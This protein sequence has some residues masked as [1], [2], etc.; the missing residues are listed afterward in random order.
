MATIKLD[1]VSKIYNNDGASAVGIQ[2][3]SLELNLGEF[4]AITGESGSGKSTF[5]NVVS[6]MDTYEEGELFIND[7]S[8][9]EFTKA[10]FANYR[11]NYVSFIFQ[12]YNL[13][14]S[15]TVLDNVMLPLISRG[16]K[17]QEAKKIAKDAI[18][19]VG[20]DK[21]IR[22]KATHLSG[23][24][25]Q[26][27]VIARALVS[28]TPIIACDEPTGNLDSE[29]AKSII[30]LLA[31][32]APNKLILF[33]THDYQ[34]ISHVATRHIIL[35]DSHLESDTMIQKPEKIELPQEEK[36]NH[37]SI[38]QSILLGLK[39]VVST[40]KK[41]TLSF[42]ISLLIS[43]S[44]IA[45]L[46]GAFAL[47]EPASEQ[48][49]TVNSTYAEKNHSKNRAAAFG[50]GRNGAELKDFTVDSDVFVDVGNIVSSQYSTVIRT[51]MNFDASEINIPHKGDEMIKIREDNHE[52]TAVNEC[53]L[54]VSKKVFNSF[55]S[56]AY[57][58]DYFYKHFL[59]KAGFASNVT[60]T[61]NGITGTNFS[62]KP[63]AV[64]LID[65]DNEFDYSLI[66][67]LKAIKALHN[68]LYDIYKNSSD[69]INPSAKDD[70][71]GEATYSV[72]DSNIVYNSAYDTFI[73][74]IDFTK[75]YLPSS[76]KGFDLEIS[77]RNSTVTVPTEDIVYNDSLP[78]VVLY[79]SSFLRYFADEYQMASYYTND[80]SKTDNIVSSLQSNEFI[81]YK[82]SVPQSREVKISDHGYESLLMMVGYAVVFTAAA[83][84]IAFLGS[85]ILGV[86]YNSQK[87]DYAIFSSLSFSRKEIRVINFVEISSFFIVTSVFSYLLMFFTSGALGNYF[88]DLAI[89]GGLDNALAATMEGLAT[90]LQS[91]Y[92]YVTTPIFIVAFF[93]FNLIF[94]F[95]VSTWI[96]NKF[97][98]KTLANN[99]RK[100]GELL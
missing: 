43:L 5:L 51:D 24:E 16:Y 49:T 78:G 39:D 10:D 59:T 21:V 53:A 70:Y 11:S 72:A 37:A 15:F 79:K 73:E 89:F 87:K 23:G 40:P 81:A 12:E 57:A 18:S 86:I 41:S 17:K 68:S 93:L 96:M 13:V 69:L 35:K 80:Y 85:L 28:D 76:R 83:I 98:R 63:T 30:N 67:S 42:L 95:L 56:Q 44:S 82:A 58:Y 38:F 31:K 26:R 71:V 7:K 84:L 29:T 25:K 45:I 54:G 32:V 9:V 74:V 6:M 61:P 20:L 62:Y 1:Q 33:V 66:L 34:S 2:N 8:T 22:H 52:P 92:R 14:D 90:T 91:I 60:V 55:V 4:V 77:F 48:I 47:I 27:T 50:K 75:V 97:D 99:L 100:G 94:A 36:R 64:Y 19:K 3:I 46:S 65:N 88:G